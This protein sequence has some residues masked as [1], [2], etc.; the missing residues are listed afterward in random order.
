MGPG[1]DNASEETLMIDGAV[2]ND[3]IYWM[4]QVPGHRVDD[5][6]ADYR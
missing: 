1:P 2:D 6:E 4:R 3:N 5:A